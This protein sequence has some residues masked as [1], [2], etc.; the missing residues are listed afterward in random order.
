M[1]IPKDS[2]DYFLRESFKYYVIKELHITMPARVNILDVFALSACFFVMSLTKK[3]Q[4]SKFLTRR[5]Q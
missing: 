4:L 5:N 1:R 2:A 3:K